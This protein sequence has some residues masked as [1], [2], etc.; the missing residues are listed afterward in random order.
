M[1]PDKV[2]SPGYAVFCA[3]TKI[4]LATLDRGS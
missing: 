1:D 3:S 2:A 4:T